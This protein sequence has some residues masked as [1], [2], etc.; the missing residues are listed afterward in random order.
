MKPGDR[1]AVYEDDFRRG[2]RR[3]LGTSVL[4]RRVDRLGDRCERWWVI[5]GKYGLPE[6]HIVW[7]SDVVEVCSTSFVAPSEE[8]IQKGLKFRKS[9]ERWAYISMAA[10]AFVILLVWLLMG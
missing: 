4:L 2:T 9:V 5:F 10:V 3:R 8:Q 7:E 6:Q 1:V